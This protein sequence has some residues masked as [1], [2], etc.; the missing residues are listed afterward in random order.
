MSMGVSSSVQR[1][2]RRRRL[3]SALRWFVFVCVNL[4]VLTFVC[5]CLRLRL[6]AFVRA[7][8]CLTLSVRGFD[9]V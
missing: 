9:H 4:F 6:F 7:C 1:A 3:P 5:V 2:L 8:V